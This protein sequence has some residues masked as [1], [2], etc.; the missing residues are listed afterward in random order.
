MAID[1]RMIDWWFEKHGTRLTLDMVSHI[2]MAL[3]GNP[4]AGK[5]R[6]DKIL[7]HLTDIGFRPLRHKAC[8]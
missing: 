1:Q 4:R 2:N 5:W 6:A 8:L 7:Q 3:Q